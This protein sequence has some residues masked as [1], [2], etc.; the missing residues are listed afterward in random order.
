M[1][2][3]GANTPIDLYLK[4]KSKG[5]LPNHLNLSSKNE[6]DNPAIKKINPSI[7]K[8]RLTVILKYINCC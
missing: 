3:N 8:I 7:I 4:F 2:P 5:I 1:L 6:T